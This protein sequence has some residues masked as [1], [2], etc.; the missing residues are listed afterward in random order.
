MA[1]KTQRFYAASRHGQEAAWSYEAKLTAAYASLLKQAG[2][3]AAAALPRVTMA[4]A[5]RPTPRWSKPHPEELGNQLRAQYAAEKKTE[6]IRVEAMRAVTTPPLQVIGLSFS[7]H[8]PFIRGALIQ[9][10][11]QITNILETTRRDL[12]GIIDSSWEDGLSIPNTAKALQ[13]YGLDNA[14]AVLIAR[15][16]LIGISNGG[17]HA[18]AA[19]SQS[20]SLAGADGLPPLLKIWLTAEDEKVRDTHVDAGDTYGEGSG[21]GLDDVFQV[22]D[23]ELQYPGDPDGDAEEVCNCRCAVSYEE[24]E[25]GGIAA[26][27]RRYRG[28]NTV[29]LDDARKLKARLAADPVPGLPKGAVPVGEMIADARE[30]VS[31]L[32]IEG[33]ETSD[34]RYIAVGAVG[35]RPLP[36]TL[37]IQL[38]TAPEHNDASVAGRIDSI[39]KIPA[40]AALAAGLLPEGRDYPAEAVAVVARGVFDNGWGGEEAMRLVGERVLRGVSVE[41]AVVAGELVELPP[42]EG[43]EFGRMLDVMLEAEVASACI[44]AFPAFA[45]AQIMLVSQ[46]AAGGLS[47]DD[48]TELAEEVDEEQAVAASAWHFSLVTASPVQLVTALTAAAVRFAAQDF[49]D[50]CMVA[51]HPTAQEA[52]DV[53]QPGGQ[54]AG[55]LHVTLAYLP[56]PAGVDFAALN[57]VV[58]KVAADSPAV[59]GAVGGAGYFAAA[60]PVPANPK[61]G[62]SDDG[63][64]PEVEDADKLAQLVVRAFAEIPPE[65][66]SGD[67][68]AGDEPDEPSE[69][70][71]DSKPEAA[72]LHPHVAL[73][74]A[75]GLSGLRSKLTAALDDAGIEYAQNHDFTPHMALGYEEQ[76]GTPAVHLAGKPLSFSHLTVHEGGTKTDHPLQAS[77][78]LTASAAGAAPVHPPSAWFD[79]PQLDEPTPLTVTA[80]GQVYGHIATWGTCHVGLMDAC[81]R[82]PRNSSGY[83]MFHLG[84]VETAEGEMIACGTYTLDSG[85]ADLKLSAAATKRHYDDTGVGA[86]DLCCGEDRHGIWAAGAVRPD[87][88]MAQVRKLRAAKPSGDWR[89]VGGAFEMIGIAAVNTPGFPVPRPRARVLAASAEGQRV[90]AL[91]AAGIDLRPS[92]STRTRPAELWR[93]FDRVLPGSS[94]ERIEALAASALG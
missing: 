28:G 32:C 79:D 37:T 23:S 48:A 20:E 35:F 40:A 53:A 50:G 75:P 62:E 13:A 36:L 61:P 72:P 83:R 66:D 64:A 3:T 89:T 73:V 88:S 18:A 26:S 94:Q 77:D 63:E 87:L 84:E 91:V 82:P 19:T 54:P 68:G 90:V 71:E 27:G 58:S 51:L 29:K 2:D 33:M 43:E 67:N 31:V 92:D 1:S 7:L 24:A 69:S 30:W 76:P 57:K 55:D 70:P 45:E 59:Q 25:S 78:A 16:E 5:A 39:E 14:R 52:S 56:N 10:G 60:P 38:E 81:V 49:T 44:V 80:D 4:A 12:M 34:H 9:A 85:H 74:D 8:N 42:E 47:G 93:L 21:I 17:S 65:T 41:L 86:A 11:T 46:E 15:T 6:P 22:G